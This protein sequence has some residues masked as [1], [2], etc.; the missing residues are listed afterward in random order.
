MIFINHYSHQIKSS[1]FAK[2]VQEHEAKA[3]RI[4]L[5]VRDKGLPKP[6]GEIRGINMN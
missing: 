3:S 4:C 5:I 2:Q 6:T 1:K